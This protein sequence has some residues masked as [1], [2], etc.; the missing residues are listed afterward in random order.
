[1]IRILANGGTMYTPA[2]TSK[3]VPE[4]GASQGWTRAVSR[5]N[6]DFLLSVQSE[7]LTGHGFALSLTIKDCPATAQD[8][9]KA[10]RAF[11]KRLERLGLVRLHWLTEWQRR[12]VPHLH[13][14][15]WFAQPVDPDVIRA[16]WLGSTAYYRSGPFSQHVAPIT[17]PAG[18]FE[19]LAKH[20]TRGV[21]HYQRAVALVP[22][23]W[24]VST[25]RMWGHIGDW[26]CADS[27]EVDPP[28]A[29]FHQYR[30]L[31]L[32][33]Q[34]GKARRQRDFYR[35]AYFSQYRQC[36]PQAT[37]AAQALPRLWIPERD[38]WALLSCAYASHLGEL[39]P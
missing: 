2:P 28:R 11:V 13:A 23:G 35:A 25:G 21:T 24:K 36:A 7:Q 6:T 12:G 3:T 39:S 8:W 37:S 4:R 33:Y 34:V 31:M 9:Q 15:V 14:A 16:H 26:P 38:Q 30:R 5:R 10:R 27:K 20:A 22:V 17:G 29:V 32:R 1:M 18:W 19:Y